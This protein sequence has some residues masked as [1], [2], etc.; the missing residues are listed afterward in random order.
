MSL[1]YSHSTA[2]MP[3]QLGRLHG[4]RGFEDLGILPLIFLLGSAAAGAVVAEWL[5]KDQWSIGEYNLWMQEMNDTIAAW[6]RLG[7]D[8][9]CWA[10]NPP[11]RTSWLAF[12][13][14]FSDHYRDH[15]HIDPAAIFPPWA[16]DSEAKPARVLMA[17]LANWGTWLNNT[18]GAD[19]SGSSITGEAAAEK[20]AKDPG[21]PSAPTDWLAVAK[22]SGIA[23]GG[24]VVLSLISNIRGA[25]ASR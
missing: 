3:L 22:W 1:E 9:G 17:E 2:D 14:R 7:W 11:Q 24:V 18:C 25:F 23:I 12:W 10:K 15:G 13:K 4:L 20:A 5:G 6:D 8:R 21:N 16:S 19:T